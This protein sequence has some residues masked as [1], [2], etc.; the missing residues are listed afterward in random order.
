MN[1]EKKSGNFKKYTA[2]DQQQSK[3]QDSELNGTD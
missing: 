1:R 2:L 3:V